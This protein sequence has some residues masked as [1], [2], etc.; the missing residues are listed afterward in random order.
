MLLLPPPQ[1]TP[2]E[3]HRNSG[4]G[5]TSDGP[6]RPGRGFRFRLED[7]MPHAL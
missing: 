5:P 3:P 4:S 2:G 6:T 7:G 1:S